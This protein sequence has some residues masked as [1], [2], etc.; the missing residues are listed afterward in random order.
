VDRAPFVRHAF[1]MIDILVS[2]AIIGV[3]IA[4]LLPAISNVRESA[5]K[6]VCGSNLRQ[7]GMGVSIYA[8]DH[9]D[10]LPGSV[11]LPLPPRSNASS[12]SSPERMDTVRLSDE[13]FPELGSKRW[14]GI[15]TLFADEYIT[16]SS[17]FYCPSH[18]GNFVYDENTIA[19]WNQHDGQEEIIANYLYRGLGPDG[20][21]VLYKIESSAAI[22][23][24]SLHSYEDLNHEG[25]FNILQ[26]GLA[27]NW[28]NDI[29]DQIAQDILL[30]SEG[31]EDQSTTVNIAWGRLDGH[32]D[33]PPDDA[34]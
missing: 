34:P 30:R 8:Q 3:L 25:G 12:Y 1:S 2:L 22:V 21:R 14:D 11:F 4:I 24:D 26:A 23:T 19:Q 10:R 28:F 13:E 20:Y 33:G 15:G 32:P 9:N 7:L 17:I 6:V 29:G 18:H 31:D 5:R 16:A 27:V